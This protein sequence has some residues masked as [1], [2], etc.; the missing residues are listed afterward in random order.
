MISYVRQNR[1]IPLF[2]K[3][4]G[5]SFPFALSAR[6]VHRQVKELGGLTKRNEDPRLVFTLLYLVMLRFLL[7][8]S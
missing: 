7:F 2:L 4:T 3:E 8:L 6:Y 1:T 5:N